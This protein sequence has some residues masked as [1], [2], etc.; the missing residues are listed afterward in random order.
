MRSADYGAIVLIGFAL[1]GCRAGTE[2]AGA[3]APPE[4]TTGSWTWPGWCIVREGLEVLPDTGHRVIAVA[5]TSPEPRP[6]HPSCR[7]ARP[8]R[9]LL[10]SSMSCHGR[11]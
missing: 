7:S 5:E 1:L 11:C 6:R 10:L 4:P 8:A 9:P 3:A 2:K